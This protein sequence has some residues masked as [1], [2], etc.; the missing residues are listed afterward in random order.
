M[1][2]SLQKL[3]PVGR[4]ALGLVSQMVTI[5]LLLAILFGV[6]PDRIESARQVRAV[7]SESLAQQAIAL[8]QTG[9]T[10]RLEAML[11]GALARYDG[12][13]SLAVREADGNIIAE[14]GPHRQFWRAPDTGGARLDN[15]AVPITA[16]TLAW[17]NVEFGF[18]SAY[19]QSL[20]GWLT[21]PP[22]ATVLLIAILG[23]TSFYLYLRRA[24]EYLDP[25]SVI[26]ERVRTAYDTFKEAILVVDPKG[27]VVLA[28]AA[29]RHLHPAAEANLTGKPASNLDWLIAGIPLSDAPL[30]WLQAME[31]KSA[32]T[33]I[34]MTIAVPGQ[35]HATEVVLNCTPII[36]GYGQ[37]RG[38]MVI[39]SDVTA[40]QRSNRELQKA[41]DELAVSKR[42]IEEKNLELETLATRDPMTGCLNRRA[43]YA[44][45][46]PLFATIIERGTDI[47][48]VMGDIDHFKKFNDT[49]GHAIGDL[50]IKAFASTIASGL[51]DA[52]ILCRF[53]GEEFCIFLPSVTSEQAWQII[54]RVRNAV[55]MEA[56]RSIRDQEGLRITASFGVSSIK[57]GADNPDA[58]IELADQALYHAKRTGRNRVCVW[59]PE[60][61]EEEAAVVTQ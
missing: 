42:E 61:C 16:D 23:M 14:A 7:L 29:F 41:L 54:E 38:S 52:D 51:R 40:L 59:G 21:Y 4:I 17:G 25:L 15:I 36:D 58:M 30:P 6:I 2:F 57:D 44:L 5:V 26:P 13:R 48:C 32:I 27:R 1:A 33:D 11:Q 9:D 39:L 20:G 24:L 60:V 18:H 50:V 22:I 53:G 34:A 10:V 55:E 47:C 8:L 3:S 35:D 19:P 28:N 49:Y 56:G 31:S 45:V 46:E 12:L 37:S 43:M